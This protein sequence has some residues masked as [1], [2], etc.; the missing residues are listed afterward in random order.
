MDHPLTAIKLVFQNNNEWDVLV[1]IM[2]SLFYSSSGF[3]QSVPNIGDGVFS[4][5]RIGLSSI[6]EC[7][8]ILK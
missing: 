4:K 1:V 7:P 8:G 5:T 6:L 2:N 3:N